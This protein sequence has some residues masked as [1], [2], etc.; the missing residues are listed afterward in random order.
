MNYPMLSSPSRSQEYTQDFKGYNHNLRIGASEFYDMENLSCDEYPVLCT[1][2][3]RYAVAQTACCRGM[4][5][6][7]FERPIWL[8]R[9]ISDPIKAS[10]TQQQL[11]IYDNGKKMQ[12][13]KGGGLFIQND[14]GKT[15]QMVKLGSKVCL[16]PD[17]M[18]FDTE[19]TPEGK[20]TPQDSFSNMEIFT[21]EVSHGT[22]SISFT[23]ENGKTYNFTGNV[24]AIKFRPCDS[25]GIIYSLEWE[26]HDEP[27]YKKDS[28]TEKINENDNGKYWLYKPAT[29]ENADN[30]KYGTSAALFRL[31]YQNSKAT[32][33]QVY[34][35]KTAVTDDFGAYL[36][37]G[38]KAG[39]VVDFFYHSGLINN[40]VNGGT[41]GKLT[42]ADNPYFQDSYN[43]N[44]GNAIEESDYAK[45]S[46]EKEF[47]NKISRGYKIIDIRNGGNGIV[48]DIQTEPFVFYVDSPSVISPSTGQCTYQELDCFAICRSVPDLAY[49][50]EYNNRLWGCS[51]DGHEIYCTKLGD[52]D[53]WYAYEGIS[54]DAEAIT[55]GSDGDFTG[56]TAFNGQILFFKED[57]IHKVY[58]DYTPYTAVTLNVK[59]VQKGSWQGIAVIDGVLYY[60][61]RDGIYAYTGAMPYKISSPLGQEVF[62]DAV[63]GTCGKKLYCSMKD[64]MGKYKLFVYDTSTGVWTRE[65][66][67]YMKF[68]CECGGEMYFIDGND[69]KVYTVGGSKG[70][71]N[72]TMIKQTYNGETYG[73][74][75]P[76]IPTAEGDF[77]WFFETGE[78]GLDSAGKKSISRYMMRLRLDAGAFLKI[79]LMYDSSGIWQ[80]YR[81]I[82]QKDRITTVNIPIVP[83]R[84]DH[85][86]IRVSGKGGLTLYSISKMYKQGSR[87]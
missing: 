30:K 77:E 2:K 37:M 49:V 16:F 46:H 50:T 5:T 29:G 10:G 32:W 22:S 47:Y 3:K 43:G 7:G 9:D 26:Q 52:P 25:N 82:T 51:E 21:P 69:G 57:C 81:T 8:D 54:T 28:T 45:W 27:T 72:L 58:G 84:C 31:S 18:W 48:F 36:F 87:R 63:F 24:T 41:L 56:C 53:N 44:D 12:G 11:W 76:F 42:E 4:A 86:K 71:L 74:Q 38:L 61:A 62:Y 13:T 60:K 39:D 23:D 68:T 40:A 19:Y 70:S 6:L 20:K 33:N 66:D 1:R 83:R 64:G 73:G 65:Q 15:R 14:N 80:E 85:L 34:D 75:N 55:V 59:G 79:S 67:T 35:W 78:I 17:K